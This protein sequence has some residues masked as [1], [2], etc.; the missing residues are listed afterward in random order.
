M[1][2][3]ERADQDREGYV[4]AQRIKIAMRNKNR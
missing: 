3:P 1:Q 2:I 4:R